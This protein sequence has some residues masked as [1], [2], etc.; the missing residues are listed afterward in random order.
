[1][2]SKD[3]QYLTDPAGD[4]LTASYAKSL[5]SIRMDSKYSLQVE[6]L[7]VPHAN[8]LAA[9]DP[10]KYLDVYVELTNVK[11]T[12]AQS[13]MSDPVD[14]NWHP[15]KEELDDGAGNSTFFVRHWRILSNDATANVDLSAVFIRP[16]F[17]NRARLRFKEV[18]VDPDFGKVIAK[19]SAQIF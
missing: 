8:T 14:A 13:G 3:T 5:K 18:G 7:Y 19:S 11:D 1:M 9:T 2:S 10:S 16:F 4:T 12:Q 15:Y 17:F 6:L